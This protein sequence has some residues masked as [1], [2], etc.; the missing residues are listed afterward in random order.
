MAFAIV[1]QQAHLCL[2]LFFSNPPK[3]HWGDIGY[4]WWLYC[5]N[6]LVLGIREGTLLLQLMWLLQ[7][8][9][10]LTHYFLLDFKIVKA[11]ALCL[12]IV[13]QEDTFAAL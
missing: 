8:S 7:E 11:L 5:M 3:H 6:F 12:F 2:L 4:Y 9:H 10:I 1:V 13:S